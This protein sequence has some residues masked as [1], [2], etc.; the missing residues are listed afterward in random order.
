MQRPKPKGTEN[1]ADN[2]TD[3]CASGGLDGD[4]IVLLDSDAY[5]FTSIGVEDRQ[6]P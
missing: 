1:D 6:W 3:A 2:Q 4:R 5:T